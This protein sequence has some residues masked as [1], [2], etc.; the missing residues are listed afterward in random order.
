VLYPTGDAQGL[1]EALRRLVRDPERLT[2]LRRSAARLFASTFDA[3]RVYGD[4]VTH[5]EDTAESASA[6]RRALWSEPRK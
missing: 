1:A 6:R 2:S 5:L 3:E 4:F